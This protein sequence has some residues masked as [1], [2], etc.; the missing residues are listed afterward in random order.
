[1]TPFVS[2]AATALW[3]RIPSDSRLVFGPL[4]LTKNNAGID[5]RHRN[6]AGSDAS[7]LR[8]LALTELR[9][10]SQVDALGRFR[11]NKASPNLV[12]G[13][14]YTAPDAQD[15]DAALDAMLPGGLA[16]WYA[17]ESGSAAPIPWQQYADRQ[18]GMYRNV[19]AMNEPEA[20]EVARAGC[21][22]R[23]CTRQRLW[24]EKS[25][26]PCLEPCALL[27]ELARR[28]QRAH[29]T[30]ERSTVILTQSELAILDSLFNW[31][32]EHPDAS[33]REGDLSS[34]GNP[35][36]ILLLREKLLPWLPA[37]PLGQTH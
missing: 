7:S 27:L 10:L 17:V 30:E 34:P 11:P 18:T 4:A 26:V 36:R 28:A 5:L 23:C 24:M 22:P 6:D 19:A 20:E 16:D 32:L 29:A 13:W 35:R 1:M 33:L 14:F 21:H 37:N 9:S 31:A 25:A 8:S 15:L 3:G 2:P 12:R